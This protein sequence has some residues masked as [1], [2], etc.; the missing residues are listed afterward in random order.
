MTINHNLVLYFEYILMPIKTDP[1]E[2]LFR[3]KEFL[4]LFRRSGCEIY[5]SYYEVLK[6][7]AYLRVEGILSDVIS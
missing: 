1:N 4:G 5:D 6:A 3:E 2:V 7:L